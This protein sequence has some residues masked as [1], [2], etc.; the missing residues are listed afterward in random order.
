MLDD[1][2]KS[3]KLPAVDQ[4]LPTN[5]AKVRDVRPEYIQPK[6]GKYGGTLRLMDPNPGPG[7]SGGGGGTYWNIFAESLLECPGIGIDL[8][9]MQGNILESFDIAPDNQSFTFHMR[10]GLKW[11]DG[12]P[13]T[14]EDIRFWWEDVI[15]N[16]KLTPNIPLIYVKGGKPMKLAIADQY[17]YTLSF[18]APFGAFLAQYASKWSPWFNFMA[19]SHYLKQYHVKY[20]SLDKLEPE[21]KDSGFNP[22]EWWRL[23]L[24]RTSIRAKPDDQV[25]TPNLT[26]WILSKMST[27]EAIFTRNPYYFKVDEAGNQLPY[28]D[29]LHFTIPAQGQDQLLPVIAGDIDFARMALAQAPLVLENKAKNHMTVTIGDEQASVSEPYLNLT[30]SDPIWR[31][32]VDDVRF[33]QGLNYAIPRQ[34]LIDDVKYGMATTET[35]IS[36]EFN[37]D[38]ANQ[39]LDAVGL[40]KKD[41]DGYRLGPDGKR[42]EIPFEYGPWIADEWAKVAQI[43]TAGW[44]KVGIFVTSKQVEGNFWQELAKGNKLKATIIWD[45]NG[46][47]PYVVPD[48]MPG[49]SSGLEKYATCPLWTQWYDSGGKE[50]EEPPP[51][52]KQLVDLYNQMQA[53]LSKQDE[54]WAKVNQNW[55]DNIW[56]FQTVHHIR[57]PIVAKDTLGNL[58]TGGYVM[59]ANFAA[60]QWYWMS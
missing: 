11:S 37:L 10:K 30:N 40:D 4:R 39:L 21:I 33:R 27:T 28:I 13:V 8:K 43:M 29:T 41:A 50:G 51:E 19:P 55:H 54:L 52:F 44:G 34:Q 22:G 9:T 24:L 58:A 49:F 12:E 38:K 20:T 1:L 26:P 59:E 16:D 57:N 42:F 53:D 31:K 14:T 18:E 6:N 56:Y 5:P 45:S 15:N 46:L 25:G 60:E 17:T 35:M 36:G 48:W 23:F 32:V 2:V 7:S 47:W 3:G